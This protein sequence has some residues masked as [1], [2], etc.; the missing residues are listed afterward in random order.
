MQINA[1]L[2]CHVMY[3][4]NQEDFYIFYHV[5][6]PANQEDYFILPFNEANQS[7]RLFY[8]TIT[9]IRQMPLLLLPLLPCLVASQ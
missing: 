4:A 5:M 3:P 9:Q 2:F 6:L 8:F 1:P 7:Q